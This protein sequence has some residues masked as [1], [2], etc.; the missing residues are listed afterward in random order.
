M[1]IFLEKNSP[2][3]INFT[4]TLQKCS[5]PSAEPSLLVLCRGAAHF[6]YNLATAKL[7]SPTKQLIIKKQHYISLHKPNKAIIHITTIKSIPYPN[8]ANFANFAT[9]YFLLFLTNQ[10]ALILINQPIKLKQTH[11]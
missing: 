5:K 4:P 7:Q 8:F 11:L 1:S 6:R 3:N 9:L 2:H 10:K